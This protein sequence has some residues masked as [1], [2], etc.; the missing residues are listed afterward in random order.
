[1]DTP[2]NINLVPA[3]PKNRD[4][5][6]QYIFSRFL[7]RK[8]Q[9]S[10]VFVDTHDNQ[11]DLQL[12]ALLGI[13]HNK[14][15]LGFTT[16]KDILDNTRVRYWS[17]QH[18]YAPN[19]DVVVTANEKYHLNLWKPS[20]IKPN[21]EIDATPFIEHLRLALSSEEEVEFLLDFIAYRYQN[22]KPK[23]KPHHAMYLFSDQQGQGKSLFKDTL[24]K[25]FGRHSIRVSTNVRELTGQSAYQFW[26]RTL[27]FV[28][29]VKVGADTRLYDAI[30]A[31]SGSDVMDADP[32]HRDSIEVQIPAQLIMLSNRSPLFLEENDRRFFV[33][34]WDT[35]LR[36]EEKENYFE[37][38]IS[39]LN[40]GGYQSI[41]GYLLERD[42]LGY[43]LSQHAPSTI[44]KNR[45]IEDAIPLAVQELV[46]FLDDNQNTYV[47][48][49][50]DLADYLRNMPTQLQT[51][52]LTLAGLSKGRKAI[53]KSKPVLYW[54][55]GFEPMKY[56][57]EWYCNIEGDSRA[58]KSVIY[59]NSLCL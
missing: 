58:L 44:A 42:L 15:G 56:N 57:G 36:G 7:I 50:K 19:K 8:T 23:N 12:G 29:E 28:E 49:A 27:L 45:C 38:Y 39:W 34:E 46:E 22:P 20:E 54:R 37:Q 53:T 52:W 3:C 6:K 5:I 47:F 30:K 31:M 9:P 11:L 35:G 16:A 51:D 18:V 25:V 17:G 41:A 2:V 33:A 10:R 4:E 40:D 59:S 32:K 1:M 26:S 55:T 21:S 43:K 48:T 13:I 24:E 14:F